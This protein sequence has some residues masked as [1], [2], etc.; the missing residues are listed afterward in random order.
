M[1]KYATTIIAIC[2]AIAMNA[3]NGD[4]R[5]PLPPQNKAQSDVELHKQPCNQAMR[6]LL[7]ALK[8]NDRQTMESFFPS[9]QV[10]Q[11][12]IMQFSFSKESDRANSLRNLNQHYQRERNRIIADFDRI[13]AEI[14]GQGFNETQFE[15]KITENAN[16][17]GGTAAMLLD[18]QQGIKRI[19]RLYKFYFFNGNWY[20]TGKARLLP[21]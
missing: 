11:E 4:G 10:Y 17:P 20:V 16:F 5:Q 7:T 12:M 3:Q 9:Q 6:R 1:K 14:N 19:F 8:N 13:R 21:I 2:L 15:W 18:N